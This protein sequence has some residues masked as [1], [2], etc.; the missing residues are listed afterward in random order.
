MSGVV[1]SVIFNVLTHR[2]RINPVFNVFF[3]NHPESGCP[4]VRMHHDMDVN[5]N[6]LLNLDTR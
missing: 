6:S 2:Y 5:F 4:L 1:S 3:F